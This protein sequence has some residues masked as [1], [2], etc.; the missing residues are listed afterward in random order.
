[1][2]MVVDTAN[3]AEMTVWT[4]DWTIVLVH[5][6]SYM[7]VFMFWIVSAPIIW[8]TF[9]LS[10]F[11]IACNFMGWRSRLLL[12]LCIQSALPATT[13]LP[14]NEAHFLEFWAIFTLQ[15]AFN[16]SA[17]T[18]LTSEP[19]GVCSEFIIYLYT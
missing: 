9:T 16:M 11:M 15:I 3:F 5:F 13:L 7:Q 6:A 19:A 14:G 17:Y 1:M 8:T 12:L 18:A 10:V 4:C 2:N